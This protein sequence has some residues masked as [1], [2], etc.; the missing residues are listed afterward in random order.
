MEVVGVPPKYGN[1]KSFE[2]AMNN[3]RSIQN[4]TRNGSKQFWAASGRATSCYFITFLVQNTEHE[5][6]TLC[7]IMAQGTK[8][9]SL[10]HLDSG[11]RPLYGMN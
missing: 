4:Q 1:S 9:H 2:R 11:W 10:K 8:D 3:Q 7:T 5:R 6:I